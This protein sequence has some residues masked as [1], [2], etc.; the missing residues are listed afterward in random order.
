VRL[1]LTL[2]LLVALVGTAFLL[3]VPDLLIL[4]NRHRT[5]I[6]AISSDAK[7][8]TVEFTF[9]G[10]RYSRH[11]PPRQ[12][13]E[14]QVYFDPEK[15]VRLSVDPPEVALKRVLPA[16]GGLFLLFG[17]PLAWLTLRLLRPRKD[18]CT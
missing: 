12:G 4:A 9:N 3:E 7:V 13:S 6:A 14:V 8:A 11:L 2:V 16:W 10:T 17:V 1:A 18:C 15:P 5:T